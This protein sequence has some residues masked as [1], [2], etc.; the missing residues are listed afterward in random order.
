MDDNMIKIKEWVISKAP[1]IGDFDNDFNIIEHGVLQSLHFLELVYLIEQLSGKI[2]DMS[3]VST[4]DFST[5]N[6]MERSF[7]SKVQVKE[8]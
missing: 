6:Q 2:I 7:F 8:S 5:L 1:G 3:L 4:S